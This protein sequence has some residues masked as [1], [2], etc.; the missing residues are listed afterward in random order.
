[1]YFHVKHYTIPVMSVSIPVWES[2]SITALPQFRELLHGCIGFKIDDHTFSM[3]ATS[4]RGTFTYLNMFF[5]FFGLPWFSLHRLFITPSVLYYSM[6][7]DWWS[8]LFNGCYFSLGNF[9]MLW[10]VSRSTT[11]PFQWFLEP[12]SWE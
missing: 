4:V 2:L 1:M 6:F 8:Y 5:F 10:Y 11:I 9:Y 3:I 12:V 7:Q